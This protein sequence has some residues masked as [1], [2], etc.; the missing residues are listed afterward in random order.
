MS[1]EDDFDNSDP[2][3]PA[4]LDLSKWRKVPALLM[5]IGGVLA[6]AGWCLNTKEFA[7]SWLLA[8]MFCLSLCMGAMFL[9]IAHHLFD[10]G[11]SVPY[12]RFCEHMA[13]LLFPWMAILFIPIAVYARQYIYAWMGP[14]LQQHPDHALLAKSPLFTIP[15]FYIVTAGCFLVWW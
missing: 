8:F 15:G 3:L 13:S 4:P 5:G 11:W 9:V 1:Q 2:A 10:A 6:G 14:K 7:F 12:R